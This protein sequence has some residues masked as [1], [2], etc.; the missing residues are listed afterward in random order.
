ML[1]ERL[2]TETPV[3][4]TAAGSRGVAME[5]RFWTLTCAMAGSVPGANVTEGSPVDAHAVPGDDTDAAQ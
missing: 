5:T 1:E 4:V 3:W 2:R